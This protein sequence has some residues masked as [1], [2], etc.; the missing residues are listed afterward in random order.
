MRLCG[1]VRMYTKS[2]VMMNLHNCRKEL[3]VTA[4][5]K[6]MENSEHEDRQQ[7]KGGSSVGETLINRRLM[8]RQGVLL[9]KAIG[10]PYITALHDELVVSRWVEWNGDG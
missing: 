8:F 4:G 5:A 2:S 9:T 3:T 1:E 6:T 7:T 10:A